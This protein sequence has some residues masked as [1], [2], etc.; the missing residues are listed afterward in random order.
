METGLG[1]QGAAER[2]GLSAHTLRYYE[3]IGLIHE[4]HRDITGHRVYSDA[5][6]GWLDFLTKLR[7]TG[8]PIAEMCRYAELMREGPSTVRARRLMLEEHRERVLARISQLNDD[9]KTVDDKITT[10]LEME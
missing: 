4:V 7:E 2:S 1:I 8:M 3:R 6:L 9:L 10:Y 5:D